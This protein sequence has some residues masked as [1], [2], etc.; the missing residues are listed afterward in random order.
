VYS[1][2]CNTLF[3]IIFFFAIENQ[4]SVPENLPYNRDDIK[5]NFNSEVH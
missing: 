3:S 5:K 1:Y 2:V 4:P